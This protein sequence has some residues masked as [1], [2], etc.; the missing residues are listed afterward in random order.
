MEV[1]AQVVG[2][3]SGRIPA[4]WL[5]LVLG[6]TGLLANLAVGQGDDQ[7]QVGVRSTVQ[8]VSGVG[9]VYAILA[10]QQMKSESELLK[11]VDAQRLMS[12]L[13]HGLNARGFQE[14]DKQHPPD[15]LITVQYGRGW[16]ANPYLGGSHGGSASG[17]GSAS[18]VELVQGSVLRAEE[19]MAEKLP[20]RE[21]RL[22]K[23]AFEK[24]FIEVIAWQYP[25]D[26]NA[27]ATL[28]WKTTMVT[29]DPD[30]R[31]LNHVAADMIAAGTPY[32]DWDTGEP[33]IEISRRMPEGR[34]N[35][36]TPKVVEPA[37]PVAGR[38]VPN[39]PGSIAADAAPKAFDIPEGD[40]AVTLK[41][42]VQ[43]SGEQILYPADQVRAV[44][45]HAIRGDFSA[46]AALALMLDRTEL[47]TT[48]DEKT[49]AFAV[50]R[51]DEH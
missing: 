39:R 8:V 19:V 40:A 4:R 50:R 33:E 10:V 5:L 17:G 29:D 49:G 23:A 27:K 30:H 37:L 15:I 31:D 21:A 28:V 20:G 12:L 43:Q 16:L 2:R 48:Q 38:P 1:P 35:V 3:R 47:V 11:P 9:K 42:F 32:F 6:W 18:Q 44:T 22:Q 14:T 34:V 24:L 41:M 7:L 36:G 26:P 45:T 25:S 46:R 51:A 13:R